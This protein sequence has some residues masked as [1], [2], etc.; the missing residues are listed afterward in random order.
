MAMP[1]TAMTMPMAG[2]AMRHRHG[3]APRRPESAVE[4][5]GDEEAAEPP[6]PR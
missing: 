6:P 3:R 1:V 4:L 5:L 2:G